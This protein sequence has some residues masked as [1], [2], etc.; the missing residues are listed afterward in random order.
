[1]GASTNRTGLAY[2]KEAT[3]GVNPGT[4]LQNINFTGEGINFSI[5]NITSN[6]IRSDRQV[7]GLIQTGAECSG[8]IDFEMQYGGYDDLL[9][10]GLFA[11]NWIGVGGGNTE[12]LEA[13]LTASNLSFALSAVANTITLGSAVVHAIVKG[14]WFR[15]DGSTSDDGYHKAVGVTGNVI[16]VESITATE[17]LQTSATSIVGSRIRNGSTLHSFWMEREHADVTQFFQ[18]KGMTVNTMSLDFSANA[19]LTGAFNFMGKAAALTQVTSGTGSNT[20]AKTTAFMNAVANVGRIA[21]SGTPITGCLVQQVT[22]EVNNNLRG[23]GAIGQLGFCDV[24][25]GEIGI[26]GN[27]NLYF[28]DNTYYDMYLASTEFSIDMRVTDGAGNTYIV[29]L[30]AC[31]FATDNVNAGSKNDDVMENTSYQAYMCS[32]GYTIEIDKIPASSGA[33][34]SSS[35][36]PSA[37]V[38]PSPSPSA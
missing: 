20:A 35:A 6:S 33:I 10:G 30:P 28:N 13:G 4:A 11:A 21:L 8:N 34:A 1:M 12:K 9:M 14:Q 27:L 37:S 36:S 19:V 26:T 7:T 24:K 31:K 32:D 3:W 5:D 23:L 2:V 22:V 25:E 15:L 38:S 18:F 17:T 16:T 29:S